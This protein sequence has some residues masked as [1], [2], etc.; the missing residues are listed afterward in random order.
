[1]KI[2]MRDFYN[3]FMREKARREAEI[4]KSR[5]PKYIK[6]VPLGNGSYKYIYSD[7]ER[8]QKTID[9]TL[10]EPL[11]CTESNAAEKGGQ[12]LKNWQQDWES[13]PEKSKVWALNNEKVYLRTRGSNKISLFHFTHKG[14]GIRRTTD[15]IFQRALLLPIAK[16]MLEGENKCRVCQVRKYA[17]RVEYELVGKTKIGGKNKVVSVIISK[18]YGKNKVYISTINKAVSENDTAYIEDVYF[19][20]PKSLTSRVKL[21]LGIPVNE[22]RQ[23]KTLSGNALDLPGKMRGSA[24]GNYAIQQPKHISNIPQSVKKS[25]S[26]LSESLIPYNSKSSKGIPTGFIKGTSDS[27]NISQDKEKSMSVEKS[28]PYP[29][30]E[31]GRW[32]FKPDL[33]VVGNMKPKLIGGLKIM[34]NKKFSAEVDKLYNGK[35]YDFPDVIRLP[36]LNQRLA[37]K[38]GLNNAKCYFTKKQFIHSRPQRKGAYNQALRI[39][40]FKRIPDIIHSSNVLFWDKQLRNFFI[41]FYDMKDKNKVNKVCFY[42]DNNG[43]YAITVSKIDLSSLNNKNYKKVGVGVAP[44]IHKSLTYP[45]ST[46]P[47]SPTFNLII[48]EISSLSRIMESKPDYAGDNMLHKSFDIEIADITEANRERKLEQTEKAL[49]A[50][51]DRQP[52][53]V[54]HVPAGKNER[55][56]GNLVLRIQDFDRG[57]IEKAVHSMAFTLDTRIKSAKGEAFNYR[58]Q[59]ELT[60]R[61]VAE[62]TEKTKEL[63]SFLIGYF[64]LPE[65]RIL[66]KSN[67]TYKGRILYSPETGEPI[68]QSEWKRFVR[69]VEDFLSRNYGTAGERIVLSAESLG[70]I[71]ERMSRTNTLE[72][73]KKMRLDDMRAGRRNFDWI[74]STAKNMRDA[75]GASITDRKQ[76]AR[77]QA[78]IDSAAQRI[79]KVTDD[80]KNNIRQVIL[81]GVRNRESK[82]KISQNLFDK[83][84]GLNRDFQRIA[85]TEIQNNVNEAYIN[86]EVYNTEEGEKVYFRRFE[87]ADGNTCGKCR[88]IR[89]KVALYSDVPLDSEKISDPYADYAIWNGKADG[90]MPTGT[91]HPY[92]RGGWYRYYPE[93]E[94]R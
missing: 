40:E 35:T 11:D 56:L 8:I 68:K 30:Q 71:L 46:L 5:I 64:A 70:R 39:D 91:L 12:F 60:D 43:N 1:M 57:K 54:R 4:E 20:D 78:A 42:K 23:S 32:G 6:K 14:G 22:S 74:S 66:R 67:L 50:I 24:F 62:L 59:E 89:G 2:L 37:L 13:N 93:L 9:F 80:V 29:R 31:N 3:E 16:A 47:A 28:N 36:N 41:P 26:D 94:K 15:E 44:T 63:Y 75:L 73:V 92:C 90:V 33:K 84:V 21:N 18:F 76:Q 58:A 52:F 27:S 19:T 65:I 69:A 88:A 10:C 49:T 61:L 72:T 86:E 48:Q 83:C 38:I 53:A 77:I 55:R 87:I 85:D 82:S 45:A 7:N 25:I 17:D 79:T 34:T 81:D 51:Y